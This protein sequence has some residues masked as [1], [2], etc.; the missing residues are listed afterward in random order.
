LDLLLSVVVFALLLF[1]GMGLVALVA[2]AQVAA[3]YG[4]RLETVDAQ[5]EARAIFG[6]MTLAMAGALAWGLHDPS[7]QPGIFACLGVINAGVALTR[8]VSALFAWPGPFVWLSFVLE[9]LLAGI[10]LSLA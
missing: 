6:G 9:V 5:N 2:P 1:L 7:M 3:S 10:F 8:L 4:L